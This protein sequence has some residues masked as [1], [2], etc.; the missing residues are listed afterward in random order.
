MAQGFS[1]RH[2]IDYE[3]MYSPVMDAIIFH[4]L[5]YLVVFE[6]LDMWLMDVVTAYL[7]GSIN[8]NV[9]VKISEDSN[10]LK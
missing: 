8:T 2:E 7:Y 6:G 5:I 10:Y 1:Q 9:Y 4:Y 3:E